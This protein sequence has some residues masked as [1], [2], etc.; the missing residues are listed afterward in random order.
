MK[1]RQK[2][3]MTELDIRMVIEEIEAWGKGIR[4]SKLT[5]II[6]ERVFP[7]TRQ[8]L[9]S[10]DEIKSAYLTAQAFLKS[11]QSKVRKTTYSNVNELEIQRLKNKIK[12]L[13][14]QVETLQKLWISRN[15]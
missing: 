12:E 15:I 5:W 4:G 9:S 1:R 7:F 11:G 2:K 6:L 3:V 10:K 8:T 13:E 14:S